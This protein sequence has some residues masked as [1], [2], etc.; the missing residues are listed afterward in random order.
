MKTWNRLRLLSWATLLLTVAATDA[1][2]ERGILIVHVKDAKQHPVAD[3][4]IGTEG[5][6]GTAVTDRGG[7][8]RIR[9]APQTRPNTWVSLQI[10][11][12]PPGKD[13]LMIS[14]WENRSLVPSFE[15][16]SDNFVPIVVAQ[17]GDRTL[18]EDGTALEA[19]ASRIAKKNAAHTPGEEK[20]EKQ[21]E[22]VLAE[23]SSLFGLTP[24][25]V[26]KAI[27][28]WGQTTNDPYQKGLAALYDKNYS[29]ATRQLSESQQ[30]R[31]KKL[32][33]AQSSLADSDFFFGQALYEQGKYRESVV[34]FEEFVNLSPGDVGAMNW[35]GLS[36][37]Q[38]GDYSHAE[39]VL[40]KAFS[41]L[42]NFPGVDQ[43]LLTTTAENLA[44]VLHAQGDLPAAEQLYRRA[45]SIDETLPGSNHD[46]A[47]DLTDLGLLLVDK[48]DFLDAEK[49]YRRA[50]ELV[51]ESPTSKDGNLAAVDTDLGELLEIQGNYAEAEV[52]IRRAIDIYQG[53]VGP[54]HP[55]LVPDLMTLAV[56]LEDKNDYVGAEPSCLKAIA[57]TE[58]LGS[59]HP[60]VPPTLR[61]YAEILSARNNVAGAQQQLQRALNIDQKRF[62][63]NH[64]DV[65]VDLNA[66]GAVLENAGN[67][68]AAE[69]LLRRARTICKTECANDNTLVGVILDNLG[70]ALYNRLDYHDAES[71]YLEAI[72]L[73]EKVFGPEHPRVAADL[74][75]LSILL[76]AQGNFTE[77]VTRCA[78]ALTID[79]K[80]LDSK[81]PII[82]FLRGTLYELHLQE[83]SSSQSNEPA[84]DIKV[85][86]MF[87]D[88]KRDK[89]VIAADIVQNV[90]RKLLA[91]PKISQAWESILSLVDYRSV[92]N[93]T[94]TPVPSGDAQILRSTAGP[95]LITSQVVFGANVIDHPE[96][97]GTPVAFAFS[98]L[99]VPASDAAHY[100]QGF[101]TSMAS[102][103]LNSWREYIFIE[104]KAHL[105]LDGTDLK[106]VVIQDASI[107][108]RYD[109]PLRLTNVYFVNC[110]FELPR[111][112]RAEVLVKALLNP[113]PTTFR[114]ED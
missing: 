31:K 63:A 8:A 110:T 28:A 38:A 45:L 111:S 98:G 20:T 77:A 112:A 44:M 17:R 92:L 6:G 23:V 15:N 36:L 33:E 94:S 90:A 69:P 102:P 74:L 100:F 50:L 13:L 68:S 105:S 52:R 79:E 18:L 14:P 64:H 59:D 78:R 25:E 3:L 109:S 5:D 70:E 39:S 53:L 114:T 65:A 4:E 40:R 81:H 72:V 66:T 82:R 67:F 99:L 96:E 71:L 86:N 85:S 57:I 80:V 76:R 93:V 32:G 1:S 41:V 49:L 34:P 106:N 29:E 35:L 22:V 51:D 11:S 10:I 104:T 95:V 87:A 2:A 107:A 21:R 48:E 88:A 73:H 101:Q 97:V 12:G 113:A 54:N 43:R 47:R 27:R 83:F 84:D 56:L 103:R 89:I 9:L 91:G 108:Y 19:I 58:G 46:L 61:R 24:E 26:D 37:F 42:D 75:D 7:T 30:I 62:G 16:E 60:N 55:D